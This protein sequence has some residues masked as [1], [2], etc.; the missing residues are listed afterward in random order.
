MGVAIAGLWRGGERRVKGLWRGISIE[1]IETHF[2]NG[3]SDM[4]RDLLVV[5][6]GRGGGGGVRE[7]ETMWESV[8]TTRM[9]FCTTQPVIYHDVIMM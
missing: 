3:S 7:M 8:A 1:R 5:M 6:S 9:I 4:R 2:F